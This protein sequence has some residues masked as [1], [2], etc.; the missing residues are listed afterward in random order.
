MLAKAGLTI[1]KAQEGKAWMGSVRYSETAGGLILT[2]NTIRDTPLY[3][4]GL[5]ID[6]MITTI[7]GQ[8]VASVSALQTILSQHKPGEVIQLAYM[9]RGQTKTA[10]VTLIENPAISV[11]LYEKAGLS[12]TPEMEKFRTNWLGMKAVN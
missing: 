11:Q 4:A 7:D 5:D 6:D 10:S 9:H 2:S 8:P 1:K 3:K 12:L